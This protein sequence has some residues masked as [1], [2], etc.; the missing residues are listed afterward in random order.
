MTN[1]I[2]SVPSDTSYLASDTSAVEVV[3]KIQI[4]E[5]PC[6]STY[7]KKNYF[8]ICSFSQKCVD[9]HLEIAYT[10]DYFRYGPFDKDNYDDE[11]VKKSRGKYFPKLAWMASL[12]KLVILKRGLGFY[13]A[14]CLKAVMQ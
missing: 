11:I 12:R 8:F 7:T 3:N 5:P 14:E 4:S 13:T 6:S 10:E 1:L 2:N 9:L